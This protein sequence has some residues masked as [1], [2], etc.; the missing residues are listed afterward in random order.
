MTYST[1]SFASR[2]EWCRQQSMQARAPLERAG[3]Q[4]EEEG[5]RDALLNKNHT[6]QYQQGP[7]SVFQRYAMGLQYGREVLRTAVVYRQFASSTRTAT[8]GRY[9]GINGKGNMSSR[10]IMGLTRRVETDVH[11]PRVMEND[12]KIMGRVRA[13]EPSLVHAEKIRIDCLN[14]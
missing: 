6:Y 1:K 14:G 2:I 3:W 11:A 4:A 8:A 9:T 5:L 12:K 10:H 7:P 13:T